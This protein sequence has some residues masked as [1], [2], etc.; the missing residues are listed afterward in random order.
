MSEWGVPDWCDE[1]AYPKP[2][3]LPDRL[4]RWEFIRRMTDYR[5]AW[6]RASKVEHKILSRQVEKGLR[7]S[8]VLSPDDLYFVVRIAALD[9]PKEYRD[10]IKYKLQPFFNP[11]VAVPRF[12]RGGPQYMRTPRGYGDESGGSWLSRPQMEYQW[13]YRS[14]IPPGW[15]IVQY[16]LTEPLDIQL[17][18]AQRRLKEVQADFL[19]EVGLTDQLKAK[20][21]RRKRK[22]MWPT[23]LRVLD[24]R[25]AGVSYDAIGR[26]LKG[27]DDNDIARLSQNAADKLIAQIDRCRTD[28][29]KW[30][31]SALKIAI[32]W[33]P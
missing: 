14:I 3:D 10:L 15:T 5:V 6:D 26:K 20:A 30:H 22:D 19:K 2:D 1:D 18:R 16:D 27:I 7:K 13:E 31:D 28:A 17:R 4:W 8:D 32:D 25:D 12:W 11:R 24:A 33:V 29:M 21:S 23:Y 9:N